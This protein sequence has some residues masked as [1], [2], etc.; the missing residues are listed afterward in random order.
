[1]YIMYTS[2]CIHHNNNRNI[3]ALIIYNCPAAS[4]DTLACFYYTLVSIYYCVGGKVKGKGKGKGYYCVRTARTVSMKMMLEKQ[5]LWA[6]FLVCL[7]I[8]WSLL[9]AIDAN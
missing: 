4:M 9:Y 1:M 5:V 3:Q 6:S 2:F 7:T 8:L